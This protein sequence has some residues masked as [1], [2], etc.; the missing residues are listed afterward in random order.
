MSAIG[1]QSLFVLIA[2][3]ILC[4]VELLVPQLWVTCTPNGTRLLG[5]EHFEPYDD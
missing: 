1:R 4:H 2:I 5:A 3:V